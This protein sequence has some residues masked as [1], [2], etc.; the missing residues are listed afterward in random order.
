MATFSGVSS[1]ISTDG[2]EAEFRGTRLT[3]GRI[4]AC[5][6]L[7]PTADGHH[8]G[9]TGYIV[10]VHSDDD[11]ASWSSPATVVNTA[12][13]DDRNPCIGHIGNRVLCFFRYL[14]V[15]ETSHTESVNLTYSDDGGETWSSPSAVTIQGTPAS[16]NG[17]EYPFEKIIHLSNGLLATVAVT[18]NYDVMLFS[19]NGTDWTTGPV[20]SNDTGINEPSICSHPDGRVVFV[21][22]Q[23]SDYT[24][25]EYYFAKSADNGKTWTT[26]TRAQG[27]LSSYWH[28]A[29]HFR[30]DRAN[31]DVYLFTSER[32]GYW[33]SLG[34]PTESE[35]LVYSASFD[36]F[37]TNGLSALSLVHSFVRPNPS[38]Y[39][40][41][42]YPVAMPTAAG[43]FVVFA[44]AHADVNEDADFYSF[45]MSGVDFTDE[46]LLAVPSTSGIDL[47]WDDIGGPY[48]VQRLVVG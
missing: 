13:Y 18:S 37:Y 7:D 20:I 32:R 16:P 6:R 40:F 46:H 3:N 22:R 45:T 2:H 33:T 35:M 25:P 19:R 4:V 31:D 30:Y 5:Y 15:T 21:A 41:Y 48:T 43:A 12:E 44:D 27:S 47:S 39:I 38:S 8:S 29:P 26:A 28:A 34:N 1:F 14:H 11:G 42:G 36:A 23:N 10:S 17:L 9:A 24:S